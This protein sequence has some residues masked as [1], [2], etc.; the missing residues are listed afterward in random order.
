MSEAP[1]YYFYRCTEC[2]EEIPHTVV[3]AGSTEFVKIGNCKCKEP[4]T[5]EQVPTTKRKFDAR[6][7]AARQSRRSR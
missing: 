6:I 7:Q 4:R 1:E 5:F 3:P 2:R